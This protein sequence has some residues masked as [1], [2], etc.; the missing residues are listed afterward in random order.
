MGEFD[1]IEK[2]EKK[3]RKL[4]RLCFC[5]GMLICIVPPAAATLAYFPRWREGVGSSGAL[6][7]GLAMAIIIA[8]VPLW[9]WLSAHFRSPA[10]ALLWTLAFV[11][12][13]MVKD[14]I[15]DLTVV[16]F[17]G[18]LS[19]FVSTVLFWVSRYLGKRVK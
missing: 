11:L 14:V 3:H 7:G 15:Y 16:A 17:W 4:S 10:P 18:M 2:K 12:L 1:A 8:A 6:G 19:A 9:R 5:L 13:Y